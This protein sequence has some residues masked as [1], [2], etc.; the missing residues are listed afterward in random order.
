MSGSCVAPWD[1]ALASPEVSVL[2]PLSTA[3]D[4]GPPSC[5]GL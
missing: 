3:P 1:I 4:T 5:A 2:Q